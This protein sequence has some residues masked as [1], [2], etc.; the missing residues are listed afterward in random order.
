MSSSPAEIRAPKK[1][2]VAMSV[3]KGIAIILMVAGHA[4]G[5]EL[6]TNFI[7]TFH[8]PLFFIAAGYFFSEKYLADPWSFVRKRFGGLYVPFVKWSVI[9]LLLHN[10]WH[11]FGILNETYGNW[12]GGV[13]HPYSLHEALSRL[14]KIVFTMSGYDEFMAGAFWFFRGL[15]VAGIAYLVL[16]KIIEGKTRLGP[17]GIVVTIMI[18]AVGFNAFRFANGLSIP[19][20]PNGGLRETWGMFFFAAGVLFRRYEHLF[21]RRWWLLLLSFLA[22]LWSGKMHFCGMNNSG[23]FKNLLTLPLTGAVGFL[24]T[25]W[26]AGYISAA[27]G[28]L[29]RML[30]YIGNNTLDILLL[31]IPAFKIVSLWKIHYYDLDFL[32]IGSHMVIHEN[33]TDFFWVMYTIAGVAIPLALMAV[34]RRYATLPKSVG[35]LVSGRSTA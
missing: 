19:G 8:M 5:P 29:S 34:W 9:Y 13:T 23:H 2:N 32:Q 6:L 7:Y 24:M 21:A 25:F 11:A 4:E 26:A 1:D 15:L 28:W 17:V 22:I 18:V 10:V 27:G 14:L 3:C 30:A 35:R 16:Y 33:N 12:T 31:H 20:I